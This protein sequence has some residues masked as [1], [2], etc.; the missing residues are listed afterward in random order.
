MGVDVGTYHARIGSCVAKYKRK[1]A[2]G[3]WK[4]E[5]DGRFSFGV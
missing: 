4:V 3:S 2:V 5:T 1:N